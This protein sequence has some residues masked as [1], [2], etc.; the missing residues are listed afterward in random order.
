MTF[1]ATEMPAE[2]LTRMIDRA[3]D[4][5]NDSKLGPVMYFVDKGKVI[6]VTKDF[7]ESYE[8]CES[9]NNPIRVNQIA[10][11]TYTAI[12]QSILP[13]ETKLSYEEEGFNK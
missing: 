11:E 7:A 6:P 2:T 12:L 5:V 8:Y 3:F 4:A 10:Y 9:N 1:K 13:N